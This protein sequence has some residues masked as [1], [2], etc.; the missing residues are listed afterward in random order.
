MTRWGPVHHGLH[1]CT[2]LFLFPVSGGTPTQPPA[3]CSTG[4]S[5]TSC[6]PQVQGGELGWTQQRL[7]GQTGPSLQ[8]GRAGLLQGQTVASGWAAFSSGFEHQNQL[9]ASVT[10]CKY[11][12]L[13]LHL[14]HMSQPAVRQRECPEQGQLSQG[15]T[16]VDLR[17]IDHS[18]SQSTSSPTRTREAWQ[19][20]SHLP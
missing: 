14:W 6:D 2:S 1:P 20:L 5:C 8:P 7:C 16:V 17:V 9:L 19:C 3:G 15:L 13:L 18:V 4:P 10:T 12:L 11:Q